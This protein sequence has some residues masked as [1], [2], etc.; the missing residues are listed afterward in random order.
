MATPALP[1]RGPVIEQPTQ[2]GLGCIA[3][4]AREG[5][6][7]L[8]LRQK[9]A[10]IRRDVPHKLSSEQNGAGRVLPFRPRGGARSSGAARAPVPGGPAGKRPLPDLSLKSFESQA[11]EDDYR[12]RMLTNG[13]AFLVCVVLIVCGVWLVG[14]IAEMR[15]NQDCALSGRRNCVVV[16]TQPPG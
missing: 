6:D 11:G 3:C 1:R 7:V 12:H 4:M 5:S 14:K 13:L 15:K 9:Q 8:I 10:P 2:Q 16:Q